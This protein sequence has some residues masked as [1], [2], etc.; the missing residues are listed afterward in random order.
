MENYYLFHFL[1]Q[2]SYIKIFVAFYTAIGF[3]IPIQSHIFVLNMYLVE[4]V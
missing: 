1:T 2:L 4:N 3:P